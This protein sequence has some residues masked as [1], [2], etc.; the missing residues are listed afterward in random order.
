MYSMYWGGT[1]CFK[2]CLQATLP[3]SHLIL[4]CLE[5]LLS[6]SCLKA[7]EKTNSRGKAWIREFHGLVIL[8]SNISPRPEVL[9]CLAGKHTSHRSLLTFSFF[10]W[11]FGRLDNTGEHHSCHATVY[12]SIMLVC[13]EAES[14]TSWGGREK[15]ML[16]LYLHWLTLWQSKRYQLAWHPHF[17]I[18]NT[19]M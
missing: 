11:M 12:L 19:W 5:L 14:N 10:T 13:L 4:S 17:N 15:R 18:S 16:L 3:L 8:V 2:I 9:F 6:L 1:D 7:S